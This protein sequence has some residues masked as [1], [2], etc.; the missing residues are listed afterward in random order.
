MRIKLFLFILL[1][2]S[3]VAHAANGFKVGVEGS[4]FFTWMNK[5]ALYQEGQTSVKCK[6]RDV[7]R[8]VDEWGDAYKSAGFT[9]GDNLYIVVKQYM[10]KADYVLLTILDPAKFEERKT[11]KAFMFIEYND[12]G[13]VK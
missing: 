8:S 6:F 12:T 1:L 11:Y 5:D 9:C 2:C 13:D 10:D 3:S 4:R 7:V